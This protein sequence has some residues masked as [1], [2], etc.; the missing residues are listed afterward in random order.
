M[1]YQPNQPK[2]AVAMAPM[3]MRKEEETATAAASMGMSKVITGATESLTQ[4]VVTDVADGCAASGLVVKGDNLLAINGERVTDEAQG[5]ALAKA[6]VGEV[7]FSILRAEELLTVTG[8]YALPYILTLTLWSWRQSCPRSC[9]R[10]YPP[11]R[12][13][14]TLTPPRPALALTLSATLTPLTTILTSSPLAPSPASLRERGRLYVP[15]FF[16]GAP[17]SRR[18]TQSRAERE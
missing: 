5:R 18:A 12:P 2:E 14:F 9:P 11:L 16:R 10:S 17:F 8:I 7:V 4:V 15:Q 3:V 6:A 13:P 1:V